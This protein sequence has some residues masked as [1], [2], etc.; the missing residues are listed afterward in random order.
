MKVCR[1]L[2]IGAVLIAACLWMVFYVGLFKKSYLEWRAAPNYQGWYQN[3][4]HR[5][6][7][8][9][10]WLLNEHP[11][12]WGIAPTFPPEMVGENAPYNWEFVKANWPLLCWLG[13]LYG[14]VWSGAS[15][16]HLMDLMGEVSREE[17]KDKIRRKMRGESPAAVRT[18]TAIEVQA[19]IRMQ[20][21][22]SGN[23]KSFSGGIVSACIGGVLTQAINVWLGLAKP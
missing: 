11:V 6:A 5:H 10:N 8:S 13:I 19:E 18:E 17:K 14:G 9:I 2:A 7:N 1:Q 4:A 15:A 12:I 3:Y 16:L 23:W 21:A 22:E 20:A